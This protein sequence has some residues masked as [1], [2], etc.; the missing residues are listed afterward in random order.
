MIILVNYKIKW[1]LREVTPWHYPVGLTTSVFWDRGI[2]KIF[3]IV[4]LR[5]HRANLYRLLA[6]EPALT[7]LSTLIPSP[8]RHPHSSLT[9]YYCAN[10]NAFLLKPRINET[11]FIIYVATIYIHVFIPWKLIKIIL[12]NNKKNALI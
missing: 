2:C 12:K 9:M 8:P 4:S 3:I 11:I 7:S 5:V 1:V 6:N 10:I